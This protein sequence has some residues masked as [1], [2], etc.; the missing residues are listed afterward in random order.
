MAD[1]SPERTLSWPACW[2]LL[3][4]ATT[5]VATLAPMWAGVPRPVHV[6]GVFALAAGVTWGLARHMYTHRR[7]AHLAERRD[8]MVRLMQVGGGAYFLWSAGFLTFPHY[9]SAWAL[10]LLALVGATYGGTTWCWHV[11]RRPVPELARPTIWRANP[12]P[13]DRVRAN[14]QAALDRARC[15]WLKV[16]DWVSV[17][18]EDRSVGV[19]AM[20][21]VRDS[22]T[23]PAS[24][25]LDPGAIAI[26]LRQVTGLQLRTDWV[27]AREG[28]Y[29]GDWEITA[30]TEDVMGRVHPYV[31]DPTPKSSAT[32][33]LVGYDIEGRH[34]TQDLRA[35]CQDCGKTLSGKTSL[36]NAK[37][38][39]ITTWSDG[40]LWVCGVAKL[41]ET[42]AGWLEPY[43][44]SGLPV[45]I[46]WIA[47]G[48]LDSL[49]M[50]AR[51]MDVAHWRQNQPMADRAAFKTI[52]VQLDEASDLLQD[53]QT[54]VPCQGQMLNASEIVAKFVK[55]N[56]SAGV[57]LHLA[58]QRST[59][60][61]W[62][63]KGSEIIA[64][65]TWRTA[66]Y[67]GDQA[68]VGRI[69]GWSHYNL[70]NPPHPGCYWL[71]PGD[72]DP[73]LLRSPYIQEV[74]PRRDRL[75]DGPTVSD[76]SWA[77]KDIPRGLDLGSAGAAGPEYAARLRTMDAEMFAY[78]TDSLAI[79]EPEAPGTGAGSAAAAAAEVH[80]EAD[81]YL[82][83]LVSPVSLPERRIRREMI[84]E[85]VR[86]AGGPIGT[87]QI[88]EELR[89]RGDP[90]SNPTAVS[91]ELA[92]QVK[93]GLL[94]RLDKGLY[95]ATEGDHTT[96]HHTTPLVSATSGNGSPPPPGGHV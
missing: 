45:P 73:L 16:V 44:D 78:L 69:L 47:A 38:A 55:R 3:A 37:W 56:G 11:A 7:L 28:P 65:M 19:R 74:D 14:W 46:D 10:A 94:H 41:W 83:Q 26:A 89:K 25:H 33:T 13:E 4:F 21:Q 23:V 66:F 95:V 42:L 84:P 29:A 85:I 52:I 76:V 68:E 75:H 18:I 51:A 53:T 58:S 72:Q 96:P 64:Q 2:S 59:G 50:L 22:D 63:P 20:A 86:A 81:A 48:R 5:L 57:W 9:W 70:P 27:Q 92:Q 35:H 60:E 54:R 90:V 80:R 15:G 31:D 77:R 40:V 36:I 61:Q 32:K 79:A 93:D 8:H 1:P 39:H 67:S 62:G 82:A 17:T 12:E 30:V 91:N 49:K 24:R 34:Y 71:R 87:F 6:I 43:R 88:I